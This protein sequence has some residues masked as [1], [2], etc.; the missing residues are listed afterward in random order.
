MNAA[1]FNSE[2]GSHEHNAWFRGRRKAVAALNLSE[3]CKPADRAERDHIIGNEAAK[4]RKI[5]PS[6]RLKVLA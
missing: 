3:P 2:F 4:T 1:S 5:K 6:E